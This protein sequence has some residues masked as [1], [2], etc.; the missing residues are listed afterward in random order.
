[1]DKKV[2]GNREYKDNVFR[3]LFGDR[4]KSAELY[5]AIKGTNYD[6]K[7]IIMNTLQNSLFVGLR[8]DISFSV[9]N[10]FI[11]LIE[12]QASINPNMGLRCLLY[13]ARLYEQL[14]DKNGIYKTKPIS[15]E[16]PEFY[17]IYNGK[18]DYPEKATI[19]LSDLFKVQGIKNN[20]ELTVTVYNANKGYNKRIMNHSKTLYEYAEFIAKVRD[21]AENSGLELTEALN[22]AVS[23]CVKE[24]ILR[25]FLQKH[26]GDIVSILTREWNLDDALRVRAEETRESTQEEVAK[27]MLL[28]N[29][30]IDKIMKYTKLSEEKILNLKKK[31]K[32]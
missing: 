21:Y 2:D 6:S 3:L 12:H 5:G 7:E 18:D 30:P 32:K 16:N 23:D 14:A 17:V 31:I 8:N 10:K 19:R 15:I 26:R 22:N 13:I 28:D 1:M 25:E 4:S 20:L 27:E 9:E 29:E 11:I 24:N